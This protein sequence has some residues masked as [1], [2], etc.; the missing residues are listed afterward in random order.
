M[1]IVAVGISQIWSGT[2]L[3]SSVACH[4]EHRNKTAGVALKDGLRSQVGSPRSV[5]F[6]TMSTDEDCKSTA[7]RLH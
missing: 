4:P 3:H 6:V 1:F 2:D 7:L 5:G